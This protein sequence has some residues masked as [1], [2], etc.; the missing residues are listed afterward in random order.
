MSD[1]ILKDMIKKMENYGNKVS[2][3]ALHLKKMLVML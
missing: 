3:S 2:T 1:K